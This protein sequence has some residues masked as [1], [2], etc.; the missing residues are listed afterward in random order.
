MFVKYNKRRVG[1]WISCFW[2]WIFLYLY[3]C[4]LYL[5]IGW[6]LASWSVSLNSFKNTRNGYVWLRRGST[7]AREM[8]NFY[9]PSP[10][11]F[12]IIAIVARKAHDNSYFSPFFLVGVCITL[13]IGWWGG[14]LFKKWAIYLQS[15]NRMAIKHSH[16]FA[17][18]DAASH[19]AK[20]AHSDWRPF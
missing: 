8:V 6:A 16:S 7:V 18:L 15:W 20:G 4:S 12:R 14:N 19:K 1:L 3:I 13:Y 5:Y 10:I 11:Q 2:E 9:P 17:L